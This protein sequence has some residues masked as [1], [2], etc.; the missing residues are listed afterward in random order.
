[1]PPSQVPP[2][3]TSTAAWSS[4]LQPWGWQA[5]CPSIRSPPHQGDTPRLL[6]AAG[7]AAGA[8]TQPSASPR[9]IPPARR[10]PAFVFAGSTAQ[11]LGT[12]NPKLISR[13]LLCPGRG[14]RGGV[15][16]PQ[17]SPGTPEARGAGGH[18]SF[19]SLL[20]LPGCAGDEPDRPLPLHLLPF[21][22]TV[23]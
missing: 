7:T 16:L 20:V 10:N 6:P 22:R 15:P 11:A 4:A 17:G 12:P 14:Q 8:D 1:M 9:L 19:G 3:A 5:G 2:V 18:P 21:V 13:K 23:F